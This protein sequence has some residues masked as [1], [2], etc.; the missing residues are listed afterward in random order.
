MEWQPL[1]QI[2]SAKLNGMVANQQFLK[3]RKVA[4]ALRN[5]DQAGNPRQSLK[6]VRD[7]L[8]VCS[9]YHEFSPGSEF[10]DAQTEGTKNVKAVFTKEFKFPNGFFDPE[11]TP[12]VVFSI[13]VKQGLKKITYSL[14][15]V[16]SGRF[17][18]SIRDLS[19]NLNFTQGMDYFICYMAMGVINATPIE[20]IT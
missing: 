14:K 19:P 16:S 8:G 2:T 11:F 6:W 20:D 7:N 13:G 12:T 4:G 15:S 17:S 5:I 1:E 3:D 10:P 9:G 18:V